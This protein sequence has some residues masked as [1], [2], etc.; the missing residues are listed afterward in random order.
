MNMK[1]RASGNGKKS[2]QVL[3]RINGY[4]P[5]NS[6]M[7]ASI[8]TSKQRPHYIGQTLLKATRGYYFRTSF[9]YYT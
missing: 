8:T 3:P 5:I 6:G 1:N 7:L 9:V 2:N 4:R